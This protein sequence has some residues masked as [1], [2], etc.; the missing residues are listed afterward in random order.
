MPLRRRYRFVDLVMVSVLL[1]PIY[2]FTGMGLA[3]AAGSKPGLTAVCVNVK[4]GLTRAFPNKGCNT[5]TEKGVYLT[6][7][8]IISVAFLGG[9]TTPTNIKS[10][11][12]KY[13]NGLLCRPQQYSFSYASDLG[14]VIPSPIGA[15]VTGGNWAGTA[16]QIRYHASAGSTQDVYIYDHCTDD[17]V[18]YACTPAGGIDEIGDG[19]LNQC[20]AVLRKT[21]VKQFGYPFS[22]IAGS[23]PNGPLSN[24]AEVIIFYCGS[25]DK[26]I[27]PPAAAL[28]SCVRPQ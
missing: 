10:I 18:F 24:S 16:K 5:K 1:M 11:T 13:W 23:D 12:P 20:N 21:T 25:N 19:K 3:N 15:F 7:P 27:A 2:F 28:V 8:E 6:D 9:S 14:G 26:L 22:L 4:T 17:M